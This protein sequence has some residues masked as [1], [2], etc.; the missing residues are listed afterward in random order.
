MIQYLQGTRPQYAQLM[1]AIPESTWAML[2]GYSYE[3]MNEGGKALFNQYLVQGGG[4]LI[5]KKNVS[6]LL[7]GTSATQRC[8]GF[9]TR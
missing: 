4:G 3:M 5:I 2:R 7:Y 6:T 9:S 1:E 8:F